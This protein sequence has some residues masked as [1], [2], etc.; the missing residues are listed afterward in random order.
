[1][2]TNSNLLAE[3]QQNVDM[4]Q[5]ADIRGYFDD[6]T[7]KITQV[8]IVQEGFDLCEVAAKLVNPDATERDFY[9]LMHIGAVKFAV[10]FIKENTRDAAILFSKIDHKRYCD[11]LYLP[12]LYLIKFRTKVPCT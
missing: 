3:L 12:P 11:V 4:T 5:F 6:P 8:G 10:P 9:D 1:M 2:T 7:S